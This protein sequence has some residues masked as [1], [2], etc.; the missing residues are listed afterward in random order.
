MYHDGGERW[1]SIFAPEGALVPG[2]GVLCYSI[3]IIKHRR[4]NLVDLPNPAAMTVRVDS[5]L[6]ISCRADYFLVLANGLFPSI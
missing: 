4:L 3:G 5:I 2:A 6:E 1:R